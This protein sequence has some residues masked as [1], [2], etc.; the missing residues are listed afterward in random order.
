MGRERELVLVWKHEEC[1][2]FLRSWCAARC[3]FPIG[4]PF[5]VFN[6]ALGAMC[7]RYG[8][9]WRPWR[10]NRAFMDIGMWSSQAF[11]DTSLAGMC[12]SFKSIRAYAT[13]MSM[14]AY[15]IVERLNILSDVCFREIPR[16][17]DMLLDSLFLQAAEER[18]HHSVVP[19]VSASA[20]AG[21]Q[22]VRLAEASPGIATVL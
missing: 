11:V 1:E 16:F 5:L 10:A 17:V 18:F 9:R 6:K 19:A 12:G 3:I 20:H 7:E 4:S 15:P 21:L 13:N 22:V 14:A 2:R 8:R